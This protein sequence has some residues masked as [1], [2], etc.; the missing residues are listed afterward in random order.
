MRHSKLKVDMALNSANTT[1]QRTPSEAGKESE[2]VAEARRRTP[3]MLSFWDRSW[4]V[5][6]VLAVPQLA[7]CPNRASA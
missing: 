6:S 4:C 7:G 1:L 3:S 2:V 5:K